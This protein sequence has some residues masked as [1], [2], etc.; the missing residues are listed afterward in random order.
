M[1]IYLADYL[2]AYHSGFNV[3]QYITLRTILGVLTA[4]GIALLIGPVMI[5]RLSHL[6]IGQNVRVDGPETHLSKAGTPTMGGLLILV[7]IAASTLLWGDLSNRFIWVVL[8]TTGVFG[9]IGWADDYL[10]LTK[11]SSKGLSAVSQDAGRN[12]IDC[13]VLQKHCDRTRMVLC[14]FDLFRRG[15]DK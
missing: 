9:A 8:V 13:P 7:S 5:R 15:R 1:L 6:Q 4:L 11:G 14:H 2:T 12:R 3:F 10:K